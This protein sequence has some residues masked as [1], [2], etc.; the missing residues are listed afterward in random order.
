[1]RTYAT[2]MNGCQVNKHVGG[3]SNSAIRG[4]QRFCPGG[5]VRVRDGL[6]EGLSGTVRHVDE[7]GRLL[8]TPRGL[9]NCGVLLEIGTEAVTATE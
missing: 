4:G 7:D 8:I 1:M 3:R 6:L 9:A 5:I 2:G